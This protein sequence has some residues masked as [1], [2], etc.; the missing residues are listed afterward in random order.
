[1]KE[2]FEELVQLSRVALRCDPWVRE[3]GMTGYCREIKG[4]V[5]EVLD[6]ISRGDVQNLKE[7]LGDVFLDL[8]RLCVLAEDIGHFNVEDVLDGV[9]EKVKRRQPF[10]LEDRKVTVEEAHRYWHEAKAREKRFAGR[11][12]GRG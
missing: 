1:M 2:R 3:A 10:L 8:A 9:V 6:A 5:D 4:E 11:D 12:S 7:E